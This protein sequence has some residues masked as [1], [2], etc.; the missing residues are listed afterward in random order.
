MI[1]SR[2]ALSLGVS[3]EDGHVAVTYLQGTYSRPCGRARVGNEAGRHCAK[4]G[5]TKPYSVHMTE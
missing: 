5:D 4:A 1:S 3:L 2:R